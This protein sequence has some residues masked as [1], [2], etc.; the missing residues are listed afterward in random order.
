MAYVLGIAAGRRLGSRLASFVS[1]LEVVAGVTFA[2]LLLGQVPA[3]MQLIGGASILLGV[4]VVRLGEAPTATGEPPVTTDLGGEL[5]PQP[6]AG[7]S[8]SNP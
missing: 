7:T 5:V 6:A 2:W 8:L 4:V 3:R 1:L